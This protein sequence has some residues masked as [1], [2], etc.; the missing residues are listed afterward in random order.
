MSNALTLVQ[1]F[2]ARGQADLAL[3]A[4][5]LM[6]SRAMREHP[7][8]DLWALIQMGTERELADMGVAKDDVNAVFRGLGALSAH[9]RATSAWPAGFFG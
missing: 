1:G 7:S 9:A 6:L 4:L 8:P 2:K 3:T 5:A